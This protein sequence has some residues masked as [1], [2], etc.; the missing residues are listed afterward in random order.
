MR[1]GDIYQGRPK[2]SSPLVGWLG[3]DIAGHA[4]WTDLA[5]MPH[6]LVAGTTGSG[7]SGCINAILSSILLHASPNEVSQPMKSSSLVAN[8]SGGGRQLVDLPGHLQ[9]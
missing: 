8:S 7:K 3:K 6:V 9:P 4:V 5:R 2:S 1:L